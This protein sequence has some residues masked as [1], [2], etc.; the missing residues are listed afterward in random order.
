MAKCLRTTGE[1]PERPEQNSDTHGSE[2]CK[3]KVM[4]SA[5]LPRNSLLLLNQL[6]F[7]LL[8][9]LVPQAIESTI[10]TWALA[11]SRQPSRSQNSPAIGGDAT[12]YPL[13]EKKTEKRFPEFILFESP[14]GDKQIRRM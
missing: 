5:R 6:F 3:E 13:S 7:S 2:K 11:L 8:Q 14:S 9:P 1:L 10:L 4:L 12:D